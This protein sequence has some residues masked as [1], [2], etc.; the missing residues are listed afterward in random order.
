MI[1]EVERTNKKT[2]RSRKSTDE[3]EKT[4][5]YNGRQQMIK[6]NSSKQLKKYQLKKEN[7][8]DTWTGSNY[9]KQ[10]IKK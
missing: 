9:T 1:L 3:G 5:V 4:E 2:T 6:G 7:S 10:D 8:E